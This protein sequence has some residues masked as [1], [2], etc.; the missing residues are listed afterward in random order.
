[1]E[2]SPQHHWHPRTVS[3]RCKLSALLYVSLVF[4]VAALPARALTLGQIDTFQDGT[5]DGWGVGGGT[6]PSNIATGGPAGP[7]DQYL[8][9]TSKGGGG[10]DAKLVVFNTSKWLGNYSGAGVTGIGMD[11]ANFGTQS[12]SIRL[13]FFI[14]KP[15]GYSTT[16]AFSL[17]A[18]SNWHHAFFPLSAAS[19]TAIG[20]PATSFDN[21]LT[22]FTGQ[23][24]I[25]DS[26]SPAVE[27]DSIAAVLGVDNVQAVP[28]P[29]AF[30]LV[31]AALLVVFTGR[32]G[33]GHAPRD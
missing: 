20:S 16:S 3:S 6:Q 4:V 11:L 17:P 32:R 24:R 30:V 27:G 13:A 29:A 9:V 19:F 7:G 15:V 26:A 22:N 12:L 10:P 2:N 28:E 14:S 18:D 21:L 31:G 5:T 1:M 25:L 33:R 23:L 8:Q